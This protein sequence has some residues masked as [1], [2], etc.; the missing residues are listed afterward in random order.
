MTIV[1]HWLLIRGLV[2]EQR[3][4]YEFPEI[5][6]HHFPDTQLSMLD[7]PGVGT[8]HQRSAPLNIGAY[9]EDF[10]RRWLGMRD[11]AAWGLLT[12]SLGSMIGLRWSADY[13]DD[14]KRHVVINTS[15]MN[16]GLPWQRFRPSV[17]PGLARSAFAGDSIQRE[18][19]IL[20]ATS[21]RP[22]KAGI[23][24]RSASFARDAPVKRGAALR[25]LLAASLFC[26]PKNI[27][28][29]TF[30]LCSTLDPM[31]NVICSRKLAAM[32]RWPIA[33]HP[34]AGHDLPLDDPQ[35]VCEKMQ[36]WLSDA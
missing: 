16:L 20:Q 34:W 17:L 35:W 24:E 28:V 18:E 29:P 9:V 19:L 21:R 11:D 10:R 8:E 6:S 2:R 14:F 22:C 26:V 27:P 13:P 30:V 36:Y 31:V 12:I 32:Q 1:K 33:E 4:W 23:A 5:F 25:Q 15:A 7:L 3:H